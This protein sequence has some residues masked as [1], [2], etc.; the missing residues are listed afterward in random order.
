M[1]VYQASEC[2]VLHTATH[3]ESL[4]LEIGMFDLVFSAIVRGQERCRGWWRKE[5]EDRYGACEWRC[6]SDQSPVYVE[7]PPERS[8]DDSFLKISAE[9][10]LLDG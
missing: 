3:V 7:G 6:R 5:P 10:S 9:C 2:T 4:T 8:L 1:C